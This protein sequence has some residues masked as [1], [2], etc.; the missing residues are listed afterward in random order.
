MTP[1]ASMRPRTRSS[2]SNSRPDCGDLMSAKPHAWS[3]SSSSLPESPTSF[4]RSLTFTFLML[5]P[6]PFSF[7]VGR[8]SELIASLRM[9]RQAWLS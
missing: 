6:C 8:Q 9:G 5:K 2:T 7:A 3:F 1:R 4:A